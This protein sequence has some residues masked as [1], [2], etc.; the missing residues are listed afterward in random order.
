[1]PPRSLIGLVVGVLALAAFLAEGLGVASADVETKQPA[2]LITRLEPGIN[3]V[4]WV[5][6]DTSVEEFFSAVPEVEAVFAWSGRNQSWLRASPHAASEYQSLQ[7][8]T[9]GL[10]LVVR[11][12]GEQP[13]DWTRKFSRASGLVSLQSGWNLVAWSGGDATLLSDIERNLQR[14]FQAQ[15]GDDGPNNPD[16]LYTPEQP[17][18]VDQDGQIEHGGALWVHADELGSWRQR[19]DSYAI[20]RGRVVG[21]EGQGIAGIY[22]RADSQSRHAWYFPFI[23]RSDG[24]FVMGP[25]PDMRLIIS[26]EHRSGCSSY[27]R[28]NATTESPDDATIVDTSKDVE[29]IEFHVAEGACG[30]RIHGTVVDADGKPHVGHTISANASPPGIGGSDTTGED[31]AYSILVT[32]EADYELGVWV[33]NSC[34]GWYDGDGLVRERGEAVP[35]PVSGGDVGPLRIEISDDLCAWQIRGQVLNHDGTPYSPSQMFSISADGQSVA[36]TY[37]AK[38]GS[39]AL[40]MHEP[41]SYRLRIRSGSDCSGYFADG[42][43]VGELSEASFIEVLDKAPVEVMLRMPRQSCKWSISGKLTRSDGSAIPGAMIAAYNYGSNATDYGKIYPDGS[44]HIDTNADDRMI[45]RVTIGDT[46]DVYLG[47]EGVTINRREATGFSRDGPPAQDLA[48]TVPDVICKTRVQGWIGRDDEHPIADALVAVRNDAWSASTRTDADGRFEVWLP[49]DGEYVL[50]FQA[51]PGCW[52]YYE[53]GRAYHPGV[54]RGTY[55]GIEVELRTFGSVSRR[56]CVLFRSEEW[57]STRTE[58]P[59]VAPMW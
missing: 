58:V 46:C 12:G 33:A 6:A 37:S 10:G 54:G 47:V 39:F 28:L 36:S 24:S 8:L 1:M 7:W 4:G 53:A 20:I 32:D 21:P 57:F 27:Y 49:V 15:Y 23:T 29:P 9:P 48:I 30:W 43:L 55:C 35:I 22:V 3:Y 17:E 5:S 59:G 50:R 42:E 34:R 52:A 38:D 14:S 41:G 45:I 26:F 51:A 2:T 13:V 25:T 11:L 19:S 40:T 31:G 56:R 18:V 44:F 16:R